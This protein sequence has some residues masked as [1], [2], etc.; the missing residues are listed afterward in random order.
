MYYDDWQPA[1]TR[2]DFESGYDFMNY[3]GT[4]PTNH[5]ARAK[6][7]RYIPEQKPEQP[8]DSSIESSDPNQTF[9]ND[10]ERDDFNYGTSSDPGPFEHLQDFTPE[11]WAEV[12]DEVRMAPG[13]REA[14]QRYD[15]WYQEIKEDRDFYGY[16]HTPFVPGRDE[17]QPAS[18]AAGENEGIGGWLDMLRKGAANL[19]PYVGSA[20]SAMAVRPDGQ[21]PTGEYGAQAQYGYDPAG[22]MNIDSVDMQSDATQS[23]KNTGYSGGAS[24][25]GNYLKEMMDP[26]SKVY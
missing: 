9:M 10:R 21:L 4:L 7:N 5:P 23:K 17:L 8:Y 3:L 12:Y 26:G 18:P 20:V 19:A 2:E 25:L 15:D 1:K 6:F 14:Q 13:Q 22:G 11:K 16:D 24:L